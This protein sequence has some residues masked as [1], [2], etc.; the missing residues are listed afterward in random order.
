MKDELRRIPQA[1]LDE[2]L[3]NFRHAMTEK[4]EN[5][6]IAFIHHKI[7]LYYMTGTMQDGVLVIR[8]DTAIFWVRRSLE[9]AK[10][11]SFFSDIRPMKSF[12]TLSEFYTDFLDQVYLETK[13]ATLD[14]LNLLKKYVPFQEIRSLTPVME[15]LRA[16]KSAYELDC[17]RISGSIHQAVLEQVAPRLLREGI[18]ETELATQIFQ[19]MLSQGGHGISRFSNPL[20]EDVIGLCAFGTSSLLTTAFDG[21]GGTGGTCIAVQSIGSNAR[22]LQK[23]QLVYLDVACGRDGYHTDKS[24]V[25]YFGDLA[26]DPNRTLIATAYAYCQQLETEIASRLVPGAIL[27][28]VYAAVMEALDPQYAAGF[29]SGGKFLGHSI[30]LY[31]DEPPVIARGFRQP[32]CENM[33]FAI[34]PKIAL[35]GIGMVGTENTYVITE[36]GAVS[37]SGS[38][39]PLLA[40]DG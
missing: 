23:G 15:N 22:K 18:S 10:T 27:E 17:M 31:M 14:W 16:V 29:M 38:P 7:N 35:P 24:I 19:E 36:Q 8:P 40:I 30:G 28:E 4:D 2:R 11:E 3:A 32:I 34:E 21:P 37:L 12:R 13:T 33:T 6:S 20:G 5:W 26:Q 39:I 9:R 25:F 1:E